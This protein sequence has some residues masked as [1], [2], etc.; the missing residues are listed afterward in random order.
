MDFYDKVG[1]YFDRLTA[2]RENELRLP[3]INALIGEAKALT[4]LADQ[5]R[6]RHLERIRT[7]DCQSVTAQTYSDMFVSLR[8]IK[9]H[10]VNYVEAYA[11]I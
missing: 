11:G 5:M 9:N 2:A 10:A 4:L 8:H 1:A 7:G 6:D 3:E